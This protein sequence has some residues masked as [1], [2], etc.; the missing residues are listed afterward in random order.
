MDAHEWFDRHIAQELAQ[1][2]KTDE[3]NLEAF[4][5]VLRKGLADDLNDAS[6]TFKRFLLNVISDPDDDGL[7][8]HEKVDVLFRALS[9]YD[10]VEL[11]K[12]EYCDG[13]SK[14]AIDFTKDPANA[15]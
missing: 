1:A 8:T 12:L 5:R 3:T 4:L 6:D 9:R 15:N 14:I 13:Q 2:P 11:R 7:E 10:G